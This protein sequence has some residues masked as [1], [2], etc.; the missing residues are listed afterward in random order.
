MTD[1]TSQAGVVTSVQLSGMSGGNYITGPDGH[2][3]FTVYTWGWYRVDVSLDYQVPY[4]S[5]TPEYYAFILGP[6]QSATCDFVLNRY[7]LTAGVAFITPGTGSVVGNEI[8]VKV[9]LTWRPYVSG[10]AIGNPPTVEVGLLQDIPESQKPPAHTLGLTR[11]RWENLQNL[12]DDPRHPAY[13]IDWVF[14]WLTTQCF[15]DRYDL[16]ADAEFTTCYPTGDAPEA[17]DTS[18][19]LVEN[20]YLD[21]VEVREAGSD[22]GT[23]RPDYVVFDLDNPE[24][25][26]TELHF[27]IVDEGVPGSYEW[28][29]SEGEDGGFTAASGTSTTG[30][31][32]VD[33]TGVWPTGVTP[34]E[35]KVSEVQGGLTVDTYYYRMPY[36]LSTFMVS[37]PEVDLERR[38]GQT[39]VRAEYILENAESP[40]HGYDPDPERVLI[41][42]LAPDL[43]RLLTDGSAPTAQDTLQTHE[44]AIDDLTRGGTHQLVLRAEDGNGVLPEAVYREHKNRWMTVAVGEATVWEAHDYGVDELPLKPRSAWA[45]EMATYQ[46]ELPNHTFF[47]DRVNP[48]VDAAEAIDRLA[49]ARVFQYFGHGMPGHIAICDAYGWWADHD[50]FPDHSI[51][52]HGFPG[53]ILAAFHSCESAVDSAHGN[54]AHEAWRSS[55]V[56]CCTLGFTE[57]IDVP[58]SYHHARALWRYALGH[59]DGNPRS[60]ETANQLA[61]LAVWDE[62]LSYGGVD[63]AVLYGNVD[64]IICAWW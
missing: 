32:T 14:P 11:L 36:R 45:A 37:P 35:I 7:E 9:R 12:G 55:A 34:F 38:D 22:P 23:G 2:Y 24:H 26:S 56:A 30:E 61:L 18:W 43:A 60:V 54:V 42:L 41:D 51:A 49:D 3:Q 33:L 40:G 58:Q 46:D 48:Y 52:R 1:G 4:Q 62:D 53:L 5:A 47:V 64:L 57:L 6:G 50:D 44:E 63:S 19:N 16:Q 39:Y 25:N 27:T 8:E 21:A 10:P 31:V 17:F 29:L 59:V 13:S 20:L 15:N 28:V